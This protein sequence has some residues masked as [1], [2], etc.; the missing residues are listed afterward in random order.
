MKISIITV[1]FND[2]EG[3]K[4]TLTS[5]DCLE[6]TDY[7]LIFQ[8]GGSTDGS[9]EYAKEWKVKH[10]FFL[11]EN[12][13]R[14]H[15]E[16]TRDGGVFYGMN[17]ALEYAEGDYCI[18]MNSGDSF[19]DK[20]VLNNFLAINPTAD[21]YTGIAAS[22]KNNKVE[23][24][25]PFAK[26]AVNLLSFW[27]N[28]SLSHQSS[29]IKTSLMKE[30]LYDTKFRIGADTKFFMKTL[31]IDHVSYQ[32]LYFI[33]S[34]FMSD[35]MS[36]DTKKATNERNAIMVELFGEEVFRKIKRLAKNDWNHII[37]EVDGNSKFGILVAKVVLL[38]LSVRK[39]F[40]KV[41]R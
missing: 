33:V 36:S 12:N 21:I 5:I 35:G 8:D 7:E 13:I 17:K 1:C 34:N 20:Y 29:F 25:Y 10:E 38:M 16:S 27:E 4:R 9:V 14:V 32:P 37:K 40:L 31:L 2:L 18:F 3:L 22:H 41:K 28:G 26:N 23:P 39:C 6:C 24:W 15:L 19:Y 30:N 11:K